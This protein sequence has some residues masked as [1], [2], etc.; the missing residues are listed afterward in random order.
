[1]FGTILP[2]LSEKFE[3][4]AQNS[5]KPVARRR[6]SNDIRLVIEYLLLCWLELLVSILSL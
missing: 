2:I 6:F 4:N 5:H 3:F 1:M